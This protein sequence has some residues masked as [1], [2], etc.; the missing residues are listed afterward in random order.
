MANDEEELS[1]PIGEPGAEPGSHP[2]EMPQN[3]GQ[4]QS[5]DEPEETATQL[6]EAELSLTAPPEFGNACGTALVHAIA[7]A[8]STFAGSTPLPSP[9][10][11]RP[12][13]LRRRRI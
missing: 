5:A 1:K 7:R 13:R 8:G 12:R 11:R 4:S 6:P 9:W 2:H 3:G 10:A